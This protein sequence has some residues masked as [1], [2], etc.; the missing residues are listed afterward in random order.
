[1][2]AKAKKALPPEDEEQQEIAEEIEDAANETPTNGIP[3]ELDAGTVELTEW[4][5]PPSAH[6]TAVPKMGAAA[7]EADENSIAE[8]LVQEGTDEADRDRR[9][10]A[11]DPDF[12]P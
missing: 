2:K 5:E 11:A 8:Q 7:E 12:E 9:I 3:P 1:M 4:D 10:A 6:G